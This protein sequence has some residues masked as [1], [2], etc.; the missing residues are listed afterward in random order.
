MRDNVKGSL[1]MVFSMAAFAIEDM[2]LKAITAAGVP[3]GQSLIALGLGG[4][5]VFAVLA[6]RNNER[7]LHPALMSRPLVI[8][9]AC[10]VV[11][12]IFYSLAFVMTPLST[13]TAIL[14]ATPLVVALGAVAL[15]GE[16][17]GWRRW[18]AI[19]AGFAGVLIILRPGT[20]AFTHLSIL[21][22]L[23]MLGFAGRDLATR[24]SPAAMSNR[25][26][27]IAG[28]LM[29]AIAGAVLLGWSGGAVWPSARVLAA[30]GLATLIGVAAYYALTLA[31][32]T[33]EISVVAPFRYFRLVFAIAIGV[34]VFG[35]R[36][37]A[38]TLLGSAIIIASGLYTA[39]RS[40]K[41]AAA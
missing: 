12:R 32:R 33:G 17:V 10:E 3:L 39:V 40:R 27:G 38:A 4:A 28:F 36:P 8:R 23:G 5:A 37:D 11:G 15:F 2:C 9:S 25:Q 1:A 16:R 30:L 41:A 29:L 20:D 24:A 6:F 18:L 19:V 7:M 13:A 35:E 31:M 22:V 34:G 21:A 26:L 14:Q